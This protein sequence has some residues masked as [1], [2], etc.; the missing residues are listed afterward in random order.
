MRLYRLL[1]I[2]FVLTRYRL[3]A[4]IPLHLLPWYLRVCLLLAPY[5]LIP[6]PRKLSRG[7]RIRLALTDLGPIF[8]KFGQLLSTRRDLLPPDIAD[9]LALLQDKV[10]PFDSALAIRQIERALGA[11][12]DELFEHFSTEALASASI[13]QVHAA[14][15]HD[16]S[17][18]VVKLVRPGIERV[19][20]K[21]IQLLRTFA[22]WFEKYMPD[23]KRFHA[24]DVVEDYRHTIEGELNL[25]SEAANTSQLKRNF[26][27]S[28]ILYV[29]EVYWDYTRERVMTMER[30][31]GI[32]IGNIQ[33]M[34]RKGVN[35]KVLAERGVEIFFMQVFR[36]SF[37]HADMHP[38]NIFVDATDPENP[39]Y[40]AIDCGIVGSLEDE[41]Q[42]YLARNLLAFFNQD[43]HQVARLHVESGWVNPN[44]KVNELEAAVRAV[45]EPIFEKPLHE[46]SFGQLLIRL[47]ATARRFEMEVQPQ[48]VLLQ[49]TL[50]NIEG[51]GRQ[52]CP[53][54]DLWK[55][56]KPYMETWMKERYG[57]KAAIKAIQRQAPAWFEQAP[58]MPQLIHD[59]LQ[60]TRQLPLHLDAQASKLIQLEKTLA[61]MEARQ[62]H[63]WAAAS[64]LILFLLAFAGPLK[65]MLDQTA[66]WV[67]IALYFFWILKH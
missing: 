21:D 11:P 51:L 43:Y 46:I 53:D 34:H 29:P 32:P 17:E 31:H 23:G 5:R 20:H 65:P 18:V 64:A 35:M 3:D 50:L 26:Q 13:A 6:A 54:L 62:R 1:R 15:L 2:L 55:T 8:I 44:T 28:D 24:I 7:A 14:T 60:E 58:L 42:N 41:D 4:F 33:E 30:I 10:P 39:V 19:I 12:I 40:I 22:T 66:F 38:G 49:K 25:Q 59:T 16:G 9:E 37:F 45:C 57:F 27:G 67:A 52:L 36:D 61:S 63:R 48:L 47:F 56:G